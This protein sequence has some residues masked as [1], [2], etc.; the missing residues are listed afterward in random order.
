MCGCVRAC[1]RASVRACV[2]ARAYACTRIIPFQNSTHFHA[3]P[4]FLVLSQTK[5]NRWCGITVTATSTRQPFQKIPPRPSPYPSIS[6]YPF[7]T[8][9]ALQRALK[10]AGRAA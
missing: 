5:R 7:P 2:R 6:P 4:A 3:I 10:P 8:P 1:V 9:S